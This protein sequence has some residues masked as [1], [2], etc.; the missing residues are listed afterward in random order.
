MPVRS[1]ERSFAWTLV[2]VSIALATACGKEPKV[3]PADTS[4]LTSHTPGEVEQSFARDIEDI[5]KR[6][7]LVVVN[8][9]DSL[10]AMLNSGRGD[11]AAPDSFLSSLTVAR[12]AA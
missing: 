5:Q 2:L 10:F 9:R 7:T 6:D 12:M 1:D 4:A 3:S 11:I 8:D